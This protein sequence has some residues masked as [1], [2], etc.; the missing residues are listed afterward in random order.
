MHDAGFLRQSLPQRPDLLFRTAAQR[1]V[2]GV[3]ALMPRRA[4]RHVEGH[5]AKAVGSGHLSPGDPFRIDRIGDAV[6]LRIRDLRDVAAE[7]GPIKGQ[8]GARLALEVE[9]GDYLDGHRKLLGGV[10]KTG[11]TIAIRPVSYCQ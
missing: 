5:D 6:E 3:L 11:A 7:N 4:A 9:V 1:H 10:W 8:R 2:E